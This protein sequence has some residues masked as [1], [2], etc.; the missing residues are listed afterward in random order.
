MRDLGNKSSDT[1]KVF[2]LSLGQLVN[3]DINKSLSAFTKLVNEGD[4]LLGFALSHAFRDV[5]FPLHINRVLRLS[6]TCLSV[7]WRVIKTHSPFVAKFASCLK[8]GYSFISYP[9]VYLFVYNAFLVDKSHFKTIEQYR[10]GAIDSFETFKKKMCAQLW[11]NPNHIS[12]ESFKTAWNAMCKLTQSVQNDLRRVINMQKERAFV[13]IIL[14][15]T[16]PTHYDYIQEQLKTSGLNLN[17]ES[18]IWRV[19]YK[20]PSVK[21]L[22]SS[23]IAIHSFDQPGVCIVS[24]HNRITKSNDV[25]LSNAEFNYAPYDTAQSGATLSFIIRSELGLPNV[26]DKYVRKRSMS[27]EYKEDGISLL[28]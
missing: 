22:A 17:T 7:A 23:A 6:F 16:N 25:N 24:L 2:L 4:S 11:Q 18:Y 21:N 13:M 14:C 5:S 10:S 3:S 19:S 27:Q 15:D 9:L 26:L 12:D 1:Q 28:G 8:S 20:S